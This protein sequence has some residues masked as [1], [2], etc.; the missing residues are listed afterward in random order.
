MPIKINELVSQRRPVQVQYQGQTAE[1]IY[2]AGA[3]SFR[4]IQSIQDLQQDPAA[5]IPLLAQLVFAWDVVDEMGEPLPLR[6]GNG[7]AEVLW[8]LPVDF[9]GEVVGAIAQDAGPNRASV[10]A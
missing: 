10:A 2:N 3:L 1:I 7:P 6:N 5:I 9:L 8:T 4:T